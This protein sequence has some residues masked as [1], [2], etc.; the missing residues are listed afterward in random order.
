MLSAAADPSSLWLPSSPD[1]LAMHSYPSTNWASDEILATKT[2]TIDTPTAQQDMPTS[3]WH[4]DNVMNTSSDDNVDSLTSIL[5]DEATSRPT[6][7]NPEVLK[8]IGT[9]PYN[10]ETSKEVPIGSSSNSD[11]MC[12]ASPGYKCA[13]KNGVNETCWRV[14]VTHKRRFA[15]MALTVSSWQL[16][17]AKTWY[18]VQRHYFYF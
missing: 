8:L 1:P 13:S 11:D 4:T 17:L 18:M 5:L 6:R 14:Q 16:V 2:S 7:I 9:T 15:R 10:V 3:Q 12:D